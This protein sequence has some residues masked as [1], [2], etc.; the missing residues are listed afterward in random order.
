MRLVAWFRE[1][2]KEDIPLAGGKGANLGEMYNARMPVPP[3]FVVTAE[4]YNF[5]LK[6]TGIQTE[7]LK[8]LSSL[9]VEDNEKLQ[10][11]AKYIQALIMNQR[12]PKEIIEEVVESY[13]NLNISPELNG[14]LGRDALTLIKTGRDLPFVAVRSSA[15]A[16][17]LPEASFA[18]QQVTL[19]NVKGNENLIRAVQE[20][21]ASLFT[22]RAIYYRVKNNF[23]HEKVL[24]AVVVQR[25]VNSEVAGVM[26][27][28][29]PSTN[30]KSEI[31]IEGAYGLGEVV[32][33]GQI[34]PDTYIADKESLKIKSK[35]TAVQQYG[36]FREEMTG[37][38]IKKEFSSEKGGRQ[39]VSDES[40]IKIAE[41]GKLIDK[42]YNKPM[43]IE[44]AIEGSK[45]YIVQARPITT[46]FEKKDVEKGKKLMEEKE[47]ILSGLAASPGVASGSVKIL[48]GP[49]EL[50]K[51]EKG[52]VLVTV[53]TN[54]DYVPAMRKAV[55]IVTDEGGIT[56]H[57]AIVS[58]EMGVP[59]IVGTEKA[60]HILKDGDVIT[61][62][63]SHG[64]V[65]KG[66]I[67]E[68]IEERVEEAVDEGEEEDAAES[69]V[70]GTKIYMNLGEPE[71]IDRY[72]H[73]S[74]DGIG[75]MRTEFVITSYVKKHPV[76]L[77]KE[78]SSSE[79]VDK[80]AEGISRVAAGIG[81]RPM[82]VR[83]SDFKTNEYRNL[84]GGA[85][86]EPHEENPMI[87]WRGVSRYIHED[88]VEAFRL[89]C[90]AVK[91]VRESYKNVHVMLPFV[92]TVDEVREVLGIMS[93][94]GLDLNH[95]FQI[96][97]MAEVP[98]FALLSEEFADLPITGCSIGSNDLTQLVLGVDRDST[99]L[100]KMGYFDERNPAVLRAISM[101]ISGFHKRGKS[102]SICG[103]APSEY[104]EIVEFLVKEG[105]D[106]ISVNPDVV[107][108]VRMKVASVERKLL[109]GK[110]RS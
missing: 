22:A 53:M 42:H 103:Q 67:E 60:T 94:E 18:G 106:A 81:K 70:T 72:K 54:P 93:S 83:F 29:N 104:D 71:L 50:N 44:W 64:K 28:A 79:Y 90:R 7:I 19:L 65:Y 74:F 17:D 62:D 24:I 15:T 80:L 51:V 8:R 5:F 69:V 10:T 23:P 63:G 96:Y 12:V 92:R 108:K 97:L 100:G 32:V 59:C 58:R 73:L 87:G 31:M 38:N 107:E 13:D 66:D 20:C 88:Y 6:G 57:A 30:D 14:K 105:I 109:L 45:I 27:T 21:W 48:H 35:K 25:M 84:D 37:R 34:T 49:D 11:T 110:I 89:E 1:L 36:L 52:D 91:R 33:G 16:E 99:K 61:V 56:S 75:L 2:N 98:S 9:N 4:A 55:A 95:D 26:F 76:E 86:F 41:L 82:I 47:E 68:Q 85:E 39:K 3:G 77:I 101:I 78:G 43:D 40:I 46:L 102:V